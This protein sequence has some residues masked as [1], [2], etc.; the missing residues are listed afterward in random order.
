MRDSTREQISD[1]AA[2]KNKSNT[3]N[4]RVHTRVLHLLSNRVYMHTAA[5]VRKWAWDLCRD[6]TNM[7]AWDRSWLLIRSRINDRQ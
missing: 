7:Q 2:M 5:P 3:M 4:V 6:H 1:T